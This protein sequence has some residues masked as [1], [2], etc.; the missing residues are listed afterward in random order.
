MSISRHQTFI[1]AGSVLAGVF[2][3]VMSAGFAHAAE[4][5]VNGLTKP[6]IAIGPE[7][8]R[9]PYQAVDAQ[10][11]A[12]GFTIGLTNGQGSLDNDLL[13]KLAIVAWV[14]FLLVPVIALW[15]AMLRRQVRQRT[16]ELERSEQRFRDVTEASGEYIWEIDTDMVYTYVSGRAAEIKG[17]APEELIGHTPLEFMPEEDIGPVSDIVNKAMAGKT[18]FTLQH[19]DISRSGNI[20]WEEVHGLPVIND[21]GKVTG[22][23]GIGMNITGRK[24]AQARIEMLSQAITQSSE[25]VI[26]TDA[27]GLIGFV[28]PAFTEITG[29]SEQDA[30][31][32]TPRILKSG[33]QDK[34]FYQKLWATISQGR[35]W[36]GKVVNH[37][38]TGEFYPAMLTISPVKNAAG[39]ITNYIGLQQDLQGYESLQ[40][41][42]HQTQKMEAIGT[43]V[44]GI[45]HNFNNDLAGITGNLFLARRGIS[46]SPK[47]V[48]K[49]E[50]AEKIAFSAAATIQQL[51]TFSRRGIVQKHPLS[52]ADFLKEAMKMHRATLPEDI[53]LR[54][55][56][57][58]ADMRINGDINQLQQV[59]MNLMSN[60]V[61]AV[62]ERE[63]PQIR[64]AMYTF[65][66]DERFIEQHENAKAGEYAC[67]SVSD[68]GN[69]IPEEQLEHVFEP[70]FTTKELGRGTGLGLSLVYGAV[71]THEGVIDIESSSQGTRVCVYL[72][73]LQSGG[74]DHMQAPEEDI[75]PGDGE[76][77]LLADDSPMVL[78]TGR[79]LL[80]ELGYKV[81]TA[82]DGSMAVEKFIE[83]REDV[84]LLIL[85]IVLPKLDGVEAL[86][87]IREIDP[88]MRAVF[89][90]GNDK[91]RADTGNYPEIIVSKPFSVH[92]LS[93]AI[94]A[95]LTGGKSA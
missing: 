1:A 79:E 30:L 24:Q 50:Q 94:H 64:I 26:I 59:L 69:G 16:T 47:A 82:E 55:E 23:R 31:G 35:P 66:A 49:L 46:D 22:L 74:S 40:A 53:D 11:N 14:L 12:D 93:Q 33:N 87:A 89:A 3:L 7:R 63:S 84:D 43:L 15:N 91:L 20:S 54:L 73:V 68:N 29:F 57:G 76:T 28:N 17:H 18:S 90:T 34:V 44:E 65:A 9:P 56:M 71:R 85:D 6:V 13:R 8:E 95:T 19:R 27:D 2:L 52:L 42:F 32:K 67:I 80:E 75:V 72:P 60:A 88:E 45:A 86:T 36:Q 92:T 21:G 62:H 4:S 37:K 48:E 78:E 38:K 70:F 5:G 25:A 61:D 51:L 41:Q 58:A 81:L 10:G 77:I 83:H 39:E